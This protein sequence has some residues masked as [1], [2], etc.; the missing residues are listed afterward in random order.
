M[1][2]AN[3]EYDAIISPQQFEKEFS[4]YGNLLDMIITKKRP[5][6]F[7]IYEDESSTELAIK[8]L[9]QKAITI[10]QKTMNFYLFPVNTG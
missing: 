4:K 5:Y 9:Q 3:C 8:D 10:D 2:V 7:V 1:F 6:M